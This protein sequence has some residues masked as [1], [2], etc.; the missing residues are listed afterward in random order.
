MKPL[1]TQH[2][3]L[4]ET[5]IKDCFN[6]FLNEDK[7]DLDLSTQFSVS[8]TTTTTAHFISE[9]KLI[10]VGTP[11]INSIFKG[12]DINIIVKEGQ[13]CQAGTVI[14][15]IHGSAQLI[16]SYERIIL[17]LIQRLSGVASL[18]AQ[19]VQKLNCSDIK[20]LDTRKTTPGIRL[21]EKYAVTIGGGYN[22]RLDL[23]HGIMLKDNHLFLMNNLNKTLDKIKKSHP[24]T[25]IQIEIDYFEQLIK[26]IKS[27]TLVDAILLD[28]MNRTDTIKCVQ[29]IK[30]TLPQC[31]IESSGGINLNNINNYVETGIH[32]ISIGALTHQA[33]SK[34]IK[35][36]FVEWKK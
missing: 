28:N 24:T 18:T 36:E 33:V 25:K 19:Y 3:T 12:C 22:H 23:Y 27:D 35:L 20:I 34:N 29:Y 6:N 8:Q 4:P 21:F 5:Y 32:A 2:T 30:E 7:V 16:L 15:H 17:N 10:F 9:E 31:F 13:L 14:A 26:Y 11:I 1:Y